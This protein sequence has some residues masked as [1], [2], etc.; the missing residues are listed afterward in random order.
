MKRATEIE[1]AE[2]ILDLQERKVPFLDDAVTSSPVEH[3][4]DPHRLDLEREKLFRSI[5]QPVVHSSELPTP[6]SFLRRDFAGLPL[7][8][9]RDEDGQVHTFINVCRHRGSRLVQDHEGCKQRFTCPYH[10][11]TWNNRGELTGMPHGELG[12]P[13]LDRAALGLKRLGCSERH[14]FIWVLANT[15]QAPDVDTALAGLAEDFEWFDA[16]SHVVQHS[17]VEVRSVNWKI[18]V[19]G[20]IE[21]YHFRVTHRKTIAPY[22]NDNLS[23]YRQFGPHLRSVLSKR[24][25]AELRD[26]PT[27]QWRLRDHSQVLYTLMASSQFLVQSDHIAWITVDPLTPSSSRIRISTL[28]PADLVAT[29]ED[30]AHWAKNHA[31]TVQTLA[32]D[33]DIGEGIQAGLTTGANDT[34]TFGRF[35]GALNAFNTSVRE[36]L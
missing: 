33:F 20:G 2:E 17:D 27:D 10:A 14:G 31:I 12:F 5:P 24:S 8:F 21:A 22:F 32:E 23:T 35:E 7:L 15:D 29:E 9:T 16:A 3:Y 34:L 19:E 25:I 11:W 13:E 6:G 1:L 26:Q 4:C 28:V 18:L 36:R 30:R